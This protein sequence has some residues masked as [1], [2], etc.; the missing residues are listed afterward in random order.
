MNLTSIQHS[1]SQHRLTQNLCADSSRSI[2]PI[3]H[4]IHRFEHITTAIRQN[5]VLHVDHF[6]IQ[7]SDEMTADGQITIETCIDHKPN[8]VNLAVVKQLQLDMGV[9]VVVHTSNN[10][11]R[12]RTPLATKAAGKPTRVTK[13]CAS[14]CR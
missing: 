10:H 3:D 2:K 14:G 5:S 7:R 6:Q 9:I 12:L 1:G 8:R 13:T 11:D 4:D